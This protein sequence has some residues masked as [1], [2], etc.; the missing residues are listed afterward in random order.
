MRKQ[1]LCAVLLLCSC[2]AYCS[3]LP[4]SDPDKQYRDSVYR[5]VFEDGVLS[6]SCHFSYAQN[7]SE[8]DPSQGRNH[9]ELDKL[10]E[11]IRVA[12]SDSSLYVK[13]IALGGACEY[14]NELSGSIKCGEFLD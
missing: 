13:R 1:L 10:N 12:L 6:L 9:Y 5:R 7:S 3:S 8:I 11:F 14:G 2:G 4:A